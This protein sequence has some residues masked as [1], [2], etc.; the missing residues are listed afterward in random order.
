M[1][2]VVDA[3]EGETIVGDADV[4]EADLARAGAKLPGAKQPWLMPV[5]LGAAM[6]LLL[7]LSLPAIAW[8]TML[9]VL[10]V[11]AFLVVVSTL[12]QRATR[13]AWS[14]QA[15]A[16]VGGQTTFR[17]DDYGFTWE[18]SLRQHRLA[19]ASLAR[20]LETPTAFLVY[21]APQAVLIVPKR[22]FTD[23]DVAALSRLL[24][25]RITP[26]PAPKAGLFANRTW[27]TLLLWV[28]LVVTFLAI[29]QFLDR[30]APP[31]H[32]RR[33]RENAAESATPPKTNGETSDVDSSP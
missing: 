14:K 13:R 19:W 6:L 4:S 20:A 29:W 18:S 1:A 11:T 16:N 12:L 7:G 32:R 9:S 25:E 15:F 10:L 27:R 31:E 22:A 8:E 17:F 28:V 3:G 5:V 33:K 30:R 26:K 21:T 24:R 23:A 2:D